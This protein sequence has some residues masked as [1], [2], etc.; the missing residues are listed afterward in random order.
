[1]PGEVAA[2]E[3][4]A[5][6]QHVSEIVKKTLAGSTLTAHFAGAVA[7]TADITVL[8]EHDAHVVEIGTGVLVLLI[9]LVIYRNLVTMLVPLATIGLSVSDRAGR[10]LR[11]RRSWFAHRHPDHHVDDCGIGRR[12]NRL[13]GISDQPLSRLRAAGLGFGSS[14]QKCVDVH[15]QSHRGVRG[16]CGGHFHRDGFRQA[17][18]VF[19]CRSGGF[20]LASWWRSWLR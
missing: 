17:W 15:R 13:R 4:L 7:T 5:A 20:D 1:M 19:D 2:P 12:G 6:Y 3:T 18:R 11:A 10:Y 16:H 14:G 8:G 9:L